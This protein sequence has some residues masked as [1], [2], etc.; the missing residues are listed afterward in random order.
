MN[1][2][3]LLQRISEI[4]TRDNLELLTDISEPSAVS[5]V[6]VK[7]ATH[8]CRFTEHGELMLLNYDNSIHLYRDT[9]FDDI[10]NF[11]DTQAYKNVVSGE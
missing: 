2:P 1:W 4:C 5:I 8:I 10:L 6:D 11:L 3:T 9:S 7:L